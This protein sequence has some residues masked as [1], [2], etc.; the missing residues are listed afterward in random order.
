[1]DYVSVAV[2]CPFSVEQQHNFYLI[3]RRTNFHEGWRLGALNLAAEVQY[4]PI[5]NPGTTFRGFSY[6]YTYAAI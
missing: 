4:C 6:S 1:M 3:W 2:A 5:A